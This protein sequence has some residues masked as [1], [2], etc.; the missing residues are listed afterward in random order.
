[1]QL[2]TSISL[3]V[4]IA[5]IVIFGAIWRLNRDID[6]KVAKLRAE[7]KTDFANLRK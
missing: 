1:M 6:T 3:D 5:I 2:D 4:V 7:L